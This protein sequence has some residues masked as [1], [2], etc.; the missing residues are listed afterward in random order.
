MCVCVRAWRGAYCMGARGKRDT[1]ART[2]AGGVLRE[3]ALQAYDEAVRVQHK[4]IDDM[5]ALSQS[6]RQA[7]DQ[8]EQELA[9]G[10]VRPVVRV[11]RPTAHD[12]SYSVM[13]C[14]RRLC[15]RRS[16]RGA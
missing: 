9:R 11:G 15:P 13:V 8:D 7:K 12:A 5:I 3:R 2:G 1:W 6:V 14:H 16:L 10:Q 4:E